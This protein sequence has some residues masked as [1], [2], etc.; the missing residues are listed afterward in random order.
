MALTWLAGLLFWLLFGHL[1]CHFNSESETKTNV[2]HVGAELSDWSS[3]SHH[4]EELMD[5][6][7]WRNDSRYKLD[8]QEPELSL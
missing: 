3:P 2:L 7:W 8:E 6:T 1:F 5:Q 4:R